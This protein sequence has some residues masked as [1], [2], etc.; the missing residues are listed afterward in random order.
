MTLFPQNRSKKLNVVGIMNG[1][2]LD[3]I[4]FV[5]IQV[6]KKNLKCQFK[7]IKSF[8]FSKQLQDQLSRAANHLMSVD[9]LAL[10]HH[11]LGRFY[12]QCFLKLGFGKVDLIGLHGQTVFHKG[13][14]ASLQI[15]EPSYLAVT[16]GCPVVSDFRVADIALGGEGAPVATFFHQQVFGSLQSKLS[17]H[18]LG[19]ISNLTLLK[20]GKVVQGFDTGPANMLIDLEVQR[21][22]KEKRRYD[23]NG[24]TAEKGQSDQA[25]VKKMMQHPYFRKKAP[26][27]CGREEFGIL[28][29]NHFSN[30]LKKLSEPDRLAT[31]TD[32]VA[33]SIAHA[34]LKHAKFIPHEIIFCGGGVYNKFLLKQIQKKLPNVKMSTVESYHWGAQS[35]EGAAFALLA[36]AKIWNIKSSL[37]KS[38]GA[39]RAVSLGK[40][41][42]I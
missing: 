32:F 37:P 4:D 29:L 7:K 19:G 31:L 42:V 18:N 25:L 17:I 40:I 38:T 41:T 28:F 9:E 15:G 21:S 39:R 22:S 34:Y 6:E 35:I 20:N 16:A 11:E 3:G 30:Q 27:S 23:R 12:S 8:S 33:T 5:F 36:A 14:M 10:L 26:K 1:T 2:S 24:A 13:R